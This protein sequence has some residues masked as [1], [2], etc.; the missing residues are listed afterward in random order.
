MTGPR[1]FYGALGINRLEEFL[2]D[3]AAHKQN[4]LSIIKVNCDYEVNIGKNSEVA[5]NCM[6]KFR[7]SYNKHQ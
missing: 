3:V 2:L 7:K 5:V 6:R 1:H 4:P